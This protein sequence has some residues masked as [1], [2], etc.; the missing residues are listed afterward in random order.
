MK[1]L[2]PEEKSVLIDKATEHPFIGEYVNFDKSGTYTCKQCGSPLYRSES[3]FKSDCGWPS[4]DDEIPGAVK[5][6]PDKDGRRTE[7]VCAN[8]GGHLGHVFEGEGFTPTNTR[9]C[10]NSISIQFTPVKFETLKLYQTAIFAGGCFWGVEHLMQQNPGVI[11]VVSGYIGGHVDHPT[12]KEVC[13]HTTG[14]AEAVRVTYDPT[15]TDYE[16]LARLF[17]EIHDPT[18][19]DG[20]GPDIGNQYRSGI[21]YQTPEQKA[22]AEK[23]ISILKAKGLKVVTEVT[24]ATTFWEAE[25]YHQDHYVR[26]GTQPYCHRYTKRF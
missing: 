11:S 24:P 10:V 22:V 12:Y 3:K 18:Q 15:K 14:H 20:Q 5:R 6:I 1:F 26:E 9:H 16:T 21:F 4:F 7:I 23:L 13:S 2:T 25:A 17:F 19:V 8:C